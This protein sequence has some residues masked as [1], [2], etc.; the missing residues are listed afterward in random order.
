MAW[1]DLV[2]GMREKL[3][4]TLGRQAGG[5]IQVTA[6]DARLE[7]LG[8]APLATPAVDVYENDREILIHADVPGGSPEGAVVAWNE[9]HGLTLLVKNQVPVSGALWE[10]EYRPA[11][12][13]RAFSLPDTA[14]GSKATSSL[15][16]GVLTI[17]IPKRIAAS[18]LIPVKAA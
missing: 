6:Q 3:R 12:W 8:E 5:Q 14:D 9:G 7:Q 17:R 16:D 10:A 11:D 1:N 15:K 18:T 2:S 4:R 13:Y